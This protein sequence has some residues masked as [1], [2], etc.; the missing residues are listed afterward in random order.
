MNKQ[1]FVLGAGGHASVL[2]DTLKQNKQLISGLFSFSIDCVRD[3]LSDIPLFKDEDDIFNRNIDTVS[4][5]NGIGSLPKSALRAKLYNKFNKEGYS[6]QQVI[7]KQAIISSFATLGEGV[8]VMPGAIIQAGAVIGENSII[9]TGSII[10]HDCIIG[11]H[12]HI[13]PGV[14]LSGQVTIGDLV[15]I[16]TGA[17][18]IQSITIGDK[19]IVGAGANILNNV[20]AG[21]TVFGNRAEISKGRVKT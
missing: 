18:I 19:A 13:A 20:S 3:V 10:E 4:L 17:N 14:T 8:Q 12:C 1:I 2:V 21:D 11:K 6:F 15:H 9:N 7:S 5:V 16:G